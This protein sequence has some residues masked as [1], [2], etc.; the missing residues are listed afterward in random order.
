[1][2]LSFAIHEIIYT[3]HSNYIPNEMSHADNLSSKLYVYS[4]QS[5]HDDC[6][7]NNRVVEC[8]YHIYSTFDDKSPVSEIA[9]LLKV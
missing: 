1:M 3:S 9:F 7:Y 5:K 6:Y 2:D 8:G 4:I